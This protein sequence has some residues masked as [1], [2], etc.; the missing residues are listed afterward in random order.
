MGTGIGTL[1]RTR[2]KE[3]VSPEYAIFYHNVPREMA[4]GGYDSHASFECFV[5]ALLDPPGQSRHS[6]RRDTSI[7]RW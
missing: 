3:L 2:K 5:P 4:L 1:T 6:I 7:R